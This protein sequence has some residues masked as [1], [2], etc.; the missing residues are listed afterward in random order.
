ME[1]AKIFENGESQAVQ[2]PPK[3]HFVGD[4]VYVKK[5]GKAVV[6]MPKD[7]VWEI[8]MDGVNS[9]TDDFCANGRDSNVNAARE[10]L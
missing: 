7:S 3:H 5:V 8:F 10:A 9:F 1:T 2:L 4:E 6:L